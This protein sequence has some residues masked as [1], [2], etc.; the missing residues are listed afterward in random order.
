MNVHLP[1]IGCGLAGGTWDHVEP[2]LTTHL[3]A[4]GITTTVHDVPVLR[5][6]LPA[7]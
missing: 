3:A 1:G 2:L 6:A 7:I 4:P 5:S